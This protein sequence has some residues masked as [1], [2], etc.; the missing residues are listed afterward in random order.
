MF[1]HSTESWNVMW[2]G[3]VFKKGTVKVEAELRETRLRAE[4]D[5]SYPIFF[6]SVTGL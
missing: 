6:W 3:E 2:D 1:A 4:D 5:Q